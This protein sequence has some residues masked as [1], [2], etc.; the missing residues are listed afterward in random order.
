MNK[1]YIG[2]SVEDLLEDPEFIA[3]VNNI[4]TGQEWERFLQANRSAKENIVLA[5]NIVK[6]FKT[7]EEK[8]AED[9]KYK[10]WKDISLFSKEFPRAIRR[11]RTRIYMRVAASIL[12]ILSLGGTAYFGLHRSEKS[13]HFTES[14]HELNTKSP[15]LVLSN[16]TKVELSN[17][18]SSVEVLK[19]E[20]AL[21]V[22]SDSIIQNFPVQQQENSIIALN[23]INVPS[24]KKTTI[25][26]ADGTRVWLNASSHFAFPQ[27]FDKGERK[28]FLEG[29]GYF[30]VAKNNS[31]PFIVS[32]QNI[33]VR[34]FGTKFN[35]S[36][37]QSDNFCETVLLEGSVT[38]KSK[39]KLFNDKITLTPNRK[40]V[41]QLDKN[42]L[43][44]SAAPDAEV[45]ISWINGWYQFS[46][47]NL[48][49]IL[50]KL[51]RY[52]NV[53]FIYDQVIESQALPVTGKLDLS[54]SLYETMT[55]LSKVARVNFQISGSK[56]IITERI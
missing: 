7:T 31:K 32:T 47:V 24:G 14:S 36:A 28:V 29:E 42:T 51:E 37:Y 11:S 10:L 6:L 48:T 17:D 20:N 40:A 41:Y 52:Y 5:N 15:M 33:D 25:I 46:N 43:V 2:Y 35:L 3:I 16:G 8:L 21:L 30:E 23:E 44:C 38:V 12:I 45:Y 19:G 1:K 4:K 39:G 54:E 18:N 27:R 56:V 26:L 9:K 53:K 34:V 50:A 13:Y 22:N 55:M 49:L